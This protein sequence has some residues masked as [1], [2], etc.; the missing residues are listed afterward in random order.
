MP[1]LALVTTA[2][3]ARADLSY[4]AKGDRSAYAGPIAGAREG[5]IWVVMQSF[6]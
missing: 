3:T 5:P 1:D 2:I 4:P 6:A